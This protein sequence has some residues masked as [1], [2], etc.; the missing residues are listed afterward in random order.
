MTQP[1]KMPI[2]H[3]FIFRTTHQRLHHTIQLSKLNVRRAATIHQ[4]LFLLFRTIG[5][6]DADVWSYEKK[7]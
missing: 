2:M 1:H 7:T 6:Y 5:R 4:Q 3:C